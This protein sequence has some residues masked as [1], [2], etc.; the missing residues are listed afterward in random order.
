MSINDYPSKLTGSSYYYVRAAWED[1]ET[2]LGQYRTLKSAIAKADAN[3]GSFIFTGEGIAIYPEDEEAVAVS[4][5][6]EESSQDEPEPTQDGQEQAETEGSEEVAAGDE[7]P[8][9]EDS[10]ASGVDAAEPA[11]EETA[12]ASTEEYPNDGN[13]E[14]ILYAKAKTLLNVRAGNSLDAEKLTVIR[15]GMLV[16]CW[17]NVTT[18]GSVLRAMP[19]GAVMRMCPGNT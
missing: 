15:K 6:T 13:T 10:D 11:R 17:R 19:L 7:T 14:P 16:R 4:E 2:Q 9:T 8:D 18:A 12:D 5:G 1:E 3:P